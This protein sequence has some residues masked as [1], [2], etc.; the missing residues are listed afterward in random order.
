MWVKNYWTP[1]NPTNDYARLNA[2]GPAGATGAQKLYDRT[3]LRLDNF[4]VA[5]TFPQ[6]WV[7]KVGIQ[8][9]KTYFNIKNVATWAKDWE[10]GDPETGGLATRTFTLGL[11]VTL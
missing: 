10:Y 6:K 11:N 8:N 1:E 3:F 4:S 5:Y 9:L 2:Q 7:N